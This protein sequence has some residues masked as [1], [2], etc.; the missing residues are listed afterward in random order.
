MPP[1]H[2]STVP[3]SAVEQ[4]MSEPLLADPSA[5]RSLSAQD[6]PDT[7]LYGA[8]QLGHDDLLQL[9]ASEG[10]S[11]TEIHNKLPFS[12][13]VGCSDTPGQEIIDADL[14]IKAATLRRGKPCV[15]PL[16]CRLPC[17]IRTGLVLFRN[18]RGQP[19]CKLTT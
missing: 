6:E 18:Q 8:A 14:F 4:D 12:D 9:Q 13:V 11:P 17:L 3:D 2:D 7:P 10:L 5:E 1:S 16:A 15:W 19:S